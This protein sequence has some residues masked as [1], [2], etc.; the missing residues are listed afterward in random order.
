[1][2]KPLTYKAIRHDLVTARKYL[3]LHPPSAEILETL[4][5]EV[6]SPSASFTINYTERFANTRTLTRTQ[7]RLR[8]AMAWWHDPQSVKTG[9]RGWRR[10]HGTDPR[11][12]LAVLGAATVYTERYDWGAGFAPEMARAMLLLKLRKMR[13]VTEFNRRKG[14]AGRATVIIHGQVRKL[15]A[16][17]ISERVGRFLLVT[18]REILK[19]PPAPRPKYIPNPAVSPAP[20]A[21]E[22][23]PQPKLTRQ[24]KLALPPRY[25]KPSIGRLATTAELYDWQKNEQLWKRCPEGY[26]YTSQEIT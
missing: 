26:Y 22:P 11:E 17:T 5:R 24:V 18:A 15:L 20:R 13:S 1:M 23:R 12:V 6:L 8:A 21:A 10:R 16:Q 4:A 25:R 2:R 9:G 19:T 3:R 7:G 14:T